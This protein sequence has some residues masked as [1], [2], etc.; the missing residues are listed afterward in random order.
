MA[1]NL[2]VEESPGGHGRVE[3]EGQVGLRDAVGAYVADEGEAVRVL[4]RA[5]GDHVALEARGGRHAVVA[6]GGENGR[7][8]LARWDD[9]G[10]LGGRG[11]ATAGG[12]AV[13]VQRTGAVLAGVSEG[14]YRGVGDGDAGIEA[15]LI[16]Q[17]DE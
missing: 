4:E 6:A 7:Q 3:D 5:L 15:G 17:E 8:L 13:V 11:C 12:F 9:G 2:A 16:R 10:G 14:V 1:E